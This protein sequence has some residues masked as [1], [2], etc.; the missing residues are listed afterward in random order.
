L[1]NLLFKTSSATSTNSH[2]RRSLSILLNTAEK[3][4]ADSSPSRFFLDNADK[5]STGVIAEDNKS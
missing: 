5:I 2:R 4:S 3:F 1:N